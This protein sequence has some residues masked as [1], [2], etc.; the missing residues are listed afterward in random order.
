MPGIVAQSKHSV[1][2][3]ILNTIITTTNSITVSHIYVT[4]IL[5][6]IAT[7]SASFIIPLPWSQIDGFLAISLPHYTST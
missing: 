3:T 5:A 2:L 1:T 4:C 7:A 6:S